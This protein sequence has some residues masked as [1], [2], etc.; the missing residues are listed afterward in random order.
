MKTLLS[1]ISTTELLE[2]YDYEPW[3]DGRGGDT[4]IKER[5]AELIVDWDF[6]HSPELG[7]M[8]QRML[9][10]HLECYP[11]DSRWRNR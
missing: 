8:R 2:N 1:T 5:W 11:N 3:D 9:R 6:T 4:T 7:A 10:V